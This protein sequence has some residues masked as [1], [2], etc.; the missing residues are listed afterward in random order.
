MDVTVG[1]E[2]RLE[3][4]KT[5]ESHQMQRPTNTCRMTVANESKN[6]TNSDSYDE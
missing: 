4:K 2:S 1:K 5:V 3:A 6:N